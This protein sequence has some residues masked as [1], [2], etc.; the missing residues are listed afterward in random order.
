MNDNLA[1]GTRHR[2]KSLSDTVERQQLAQRTVDKVSLVRDW[3]IATPVS[4]WHLAFPGTPMPEGEE[5]FG[6]E[7]IEGTSQRVV[8]T[9]SDGKPRIWC[10]RVQRSH[11]KS[12]EMKT[13]LAE[14]HSD[15]DE[16]YAKA[17]KTKHESASSSLFD[18]SKHVKAIDLSALQ[19]LAHKSAAAIKIEVPEDVDSDESGEEAV[20][21]TKRLQHIGGKPVAKAKGGS[22]VKGKPRPGAVSSGAGSSGGGLSAPMA[23]SGAAVAR[24]TASSAPMASSGAVVSAST[25]ERDEAGTASVGQADVTIKRRGRPPLR[26]TRDLSNNAEQALGPLE[27]KFSEF[28][29]LTRDCLQVDIDCNLSDEKSVKEFKQKINAL[30]K[31]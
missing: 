11:E 27:D 10:Y 4:K 13:I 5:H 30:L 2:L 8:Y 21:F 26:K 9:E 15:D 24:A 29:G 7:T 6:H 17:V 22:T 1:P 28:Q 31:K 23:S 18:R 16:E 3:E 14:V 12:V 19:Q 20:G 25:E